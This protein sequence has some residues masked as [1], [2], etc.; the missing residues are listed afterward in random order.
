MVPTEMTQS[1][2]NSVGLYELA[3]LGI[4]RWWI[5]AVSMLASLAIASWVA[6]TSVPTYRAE[7]VLMLAQPADQADSRLPDQLGGLAALAG[8]SLRGA[9]DRKAEAL[10]T[11]QSRLLSDEFVRDKNLLPVLFDQRWDS[12]Q[13]RWNETAKVPTLWDAR[14]LIANKILKVLEDRKTG[15]IT[16]A[17]EWK[18]PELA[19]EWAKELVARTNRMLQ[20]AS[21]R[22]SNRNIE[23]LKKQL[24]ETEILGVRDALNKI[25]ESELKTSMLAQRSE[26]YVLRMVDPPVPPE[27]R[28]WP[29]RTLIMLLGMISG[30]FIWFATL[31]LWKFVAVGVTAVRHRPKQTW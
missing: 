8:L 13:Q 4:R 10:A 30:L 20:E 21:Y 25:M 18:D 24:G 26:D 29:R 31:L 6:F 28:I 11:L 15:L 12:S 14:K 22:R 27:E 19:A 17:V 5:G 2:P 16:L 23:F 3:E 1:I 7:A 9:G